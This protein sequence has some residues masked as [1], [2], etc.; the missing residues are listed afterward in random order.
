MGHLLYLIES[1]YWSTT[2]TQATS[3][4]HTYTFSQTLYTCIINSMQFKNQNAPPTTQMP[5]WGF[6]PVTIPHFDHTLHTRRNHYS[7]FQ[8]HRLV[9]LHFKL[10][11]NRITSHVLL[12]VW[13]FL[14]NILKRLPLR[15]MILTSGYS[16]PCLILSF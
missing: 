2:H 1:F 4:N 9:F 14:F 11:I 15:S 3:T 8:C 16:W 5:S 10:Y 7:D 13:L 12:L 6:L